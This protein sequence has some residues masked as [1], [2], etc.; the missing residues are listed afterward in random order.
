MSLSHTTEVH[1]PTRL[2]PGAIGDAMAVDSLPAAVVRLASAIS[3]VPIDS[4]SVCG[5]RLRTT[6]QGR[7]FNIGARQRR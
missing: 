5:S 2:A 6:P 7:W 4:V 1:A 3:V